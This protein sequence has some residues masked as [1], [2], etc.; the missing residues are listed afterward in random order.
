MKREPARAL[1]ERSGHDD[2]AVRLARAEDEVVWER[3]VSTCPEATFFHR[4]GWQR[5]LQGTFGHRTY[6]LLAERD[7]EPV[8]VLPLAHVRSRLFGN[9]LASLPFC[10]YGGAAC[11]DPGA[12]PLLHHAAVD[13]AERLKVDNLELRNRQP[14]EPQ[15]ARQDLYVT[16]RKA[17]DPRPEA[18][19]TAMPAKQRTMVRKG[20]KAG[21][22]GVVEPDV[23]NFFALYA[24]N[25]HRHGT[26][27][28]PRSY[29]EALQH[30]FGDACEVLTVFDPQ[31]AAIS[32][33]LS[34]YFRDEVL[35]YYAGDQV[36]ARQLAA[37]D[38]KYWELMRMSCERGCRVFD[39]G[40]SRRGT[41]SYEFKRHWGFEP[42][43][44]HYEFCIVRGTTVPQNNPNNPKYR[45]FIALWRR[46]PRRLATRVGPYIVRNLG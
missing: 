25:M 45:L 7:G 9:S 29:F 11:S 26:P 28:L 18:N 16:F 20:M 19:L 21:L 10:V 22:R 38:F 43:P 24:D 39:Y 4:F 1:R 31:G 6:F 5:I 17:L 13:L 35:P 8:G 2:I 41:G 34:F 12:R 42:E 14:H 46:L 37:N 27:A 3:F 44:L 32:S 36:R 33:V 30:E 40:R 15:W 23:G